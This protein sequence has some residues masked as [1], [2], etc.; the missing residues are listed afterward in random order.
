MKTLSYMLLYG[1]L[2]TC[3]LAVAEETASPRG[4]VS[5]QLQAYTPQHRVLVSE[6]LQLAHGMVEDP[7]PHFGR[8]DRHAYALLPPSQRRKS[9][10]LLGHGF[11]ERG[12]YEAAQTALARVDG[13]LP[14][15]IRQDFTLLQAQV[16]LA[17]GAHEHAAKLLE[18]LAG[19]RSASPYA[20][21]NL[22]VAQLRSGR[23][24]QAIETL[25]AMGSLNAESVEE[26]ALRDQANI[27][28]GYLYLERRNTR[29]ARQALQRASL[30]GPYAR[31][32]LLA[33]GWVEWQAR[34]PRLAQSA[35]AELLEDNP[36]SPI[37]QEALSGVPQALWRLESHTQARKKF[38]AA[39]A[40]YQAQLDRLDEVIAQARDDTAWLSTTLADA[41]PEDL[42][43]RTVWQRMDHTALA[44]YL[45]VLTDDLVLQ[46]T[47][48]RY[49]A[50]L[51]LNNLTASPSR[52]RA[53]MENQLG[54][55]V[56]QP[57][58]TGLDDDLRLL[59][60]QIPNLLAQQ[61]KRV[62]G[63]VLK[64]LARQRQQLRRYLVDA[65]Y[66]RARLLDELA[67]KKS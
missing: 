63:Q 67:D 8:F 58:P 43:V 33:L 46:Q 55:T 64:V 2:A 4:G 34:N 53:A 20:Q 24:S 17:R 30:N 12:D 29:K 1:I 41:S 22:A 52:L 3:G 56:N 48:N 61:R 25:E 23:Q 42:G 7:V 62:Q 37:T 51:R 59:R 54:I 50:L 10:Y 49:L 65:Q 21:Y 28:L 40:L 14:E 9:W 26:E 44:P 31:Q 66:A 39:I 60:Q 16:S 45:G 19:R 15:E 11:Y 27:T 32:A 35:W 36:A 5:P 6:W 38:D 13:R 47:L 57:L 18:S